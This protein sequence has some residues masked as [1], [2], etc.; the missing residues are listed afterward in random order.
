MAAPGALIGPAISLSL[1]WQLPSLS[2]GPSSG[3]ALATVVG[4]LIDTVD[5]FG[6]FD[7]QPHATMVCFCGKMQ[8]ER[9]EIE[10]KILQVSCCLV[11]FS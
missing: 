1:P 3:A 5:A 4:V 6:L 7:M 9:S 10:L 11:S 2:L 8:I